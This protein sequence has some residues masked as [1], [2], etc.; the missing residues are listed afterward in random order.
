MLEANTTLWLTYGSLFKRGKQ[1]RNKYG[2]SS[3]GTSEIETRIVDGRT[4]AGR[5]SRV[6]KVFSFPTFGKP[7]Q[8][9]RMP[10]RW[11]EYIIHECIR[12]FYVM[13]FVRLVV[14]TA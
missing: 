6:L 9:I 4:G 14:L 10:M 3:G 11:V 7:I 1:L 13:F 8:P 5:K 2:L 12:I